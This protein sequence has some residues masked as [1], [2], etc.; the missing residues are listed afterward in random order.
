MRMNI[1]IEDE[2][3]FVDIRTFREFE[4]IICDVVE[5]YINDIDNYDNTYYL[6]INSK[7]YNV[8][9]E[10]GNRINGDDEKFDLNKFVQR[11]ENGALEVDIDAVNEVANKFLFVK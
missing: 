2:F 8:A 5:E 3:G 7:T 6:V 1:I 9:I 4:N 11:N 10:N